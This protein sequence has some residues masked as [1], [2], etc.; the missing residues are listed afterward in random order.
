M[1]A[2]PSSPTCSEVWE[3]IYRLAMEGSILRSVWLGTPD[4]LSMRR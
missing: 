1:E 3:P 4:P 2:G